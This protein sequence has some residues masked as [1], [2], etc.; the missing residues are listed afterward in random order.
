MK[1][2]EQNLVVI[3]DLH[4]GCQFGLCPPAVKLDGGQMVHQSRAQVAVWEWWTEFWDRWVPRVTNGQPFD[5]AVNGDIVD[6]RHHNATTQISQNL[7]DQ[8]KIAVVVLAPV[9]RRARR[10]YVIRGTEAHVGPAAEQEETIAKE[11]GAVPDEE[12]NYSRQELWIQVGAWLCHLAHHIGTTNS[13]A[14]ESTAVLKEL[15]AQFEDAAQ[16]GEKP[17][18][19]VVR[20]HRHRCLSVEIPGLAGDMVSV[21]TPGWQLK[22]PFAYRLGM[23]RNSAPQIGGILIRQGDEEP[24]IRKFVRSLPR[25]KR[26]AAEG[27]A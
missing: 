10:V 23:G 14:Y 7:A 13:A 19:C 2:K 3:S 11:L 22:T 5:V 16:W 21:V 25:A 26:I 18:Q 8:S 12:G 6:G 20:S 9:A 24:H 15:V 1:K 17:P 27:V 4:C